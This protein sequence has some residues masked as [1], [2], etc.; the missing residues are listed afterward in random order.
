MEEVIAARCGR[1]CSL[2]RTKER[3]KGFHGW[4]DFCIS[5]GTYEEFGGVGREISVPAHLFCAFGGVD[6]PSLCGALDGSNARGLRE[7]QVTGYFIRALY[8]GVPAGDSMLFQINSS[9]PRKEETNE[10][11]KVGRKRDNK[12]KKS[13]EDRIHAEVVPL[14]RRRTTAASTPTPSPGSSFSSPS[15][16][17]T[18]SSD[19]AAGSSSTAPTL[20]LPSTPYKSSDQ[21]LLV[22]YQ[23]NQLMGLQIENAQLKAQLNDK[24]KTDLNGYSSLDLAQA[25]LSR[26]ELVPRQNLFGPPI[27][28]LSVLLT[29]LLRAS[30]PSLFPSETSDDY[31]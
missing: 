3:Q 17:M 23:S 25:L 2:E 16:V 8:N 31:A 24:L 10:E 18:P 11:N 14:K 6:L 4:P 29:S 12:R 20:A 9:R 5:F 21:N 22:V 19:F 13:E 1:D 30:N 27:V 7:K 26:C 28:E 15:S